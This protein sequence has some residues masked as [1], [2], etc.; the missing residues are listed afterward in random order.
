MFRIRPRARDEHRISHAENSEPH[1]RRRTEILFSKPVPCVREPA[2]HRSG[3]ETGGSSLI[4]FRR[5]DGGLFMQSLSEWI[6]PRPISHLPYVRSR[7]QEPGRNGSSL[8]ELR[9]EPEIFSSGASLRTLQRAADESHPPNKIQ[10]R[11]PIGRTPRAPSVFSIHRSFPKRR[12]R[13]GPT[14][15]PTPHQIQATGIQSELPVH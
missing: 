10:R 13:S 7:I 2:P 14:G 1:R 8:P 9:G 12:Y 4:G 11:Y 15:S 3:N 6:H 5:P